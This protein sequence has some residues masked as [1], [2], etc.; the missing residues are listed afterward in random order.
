[1]RTGIVEQKGAGER[2][3]GKPLLGSE[4]QSC[5]PHVEVRGCC[6]K[7]IGSPQFE[8]SKLRAISY[9]VAEDDSFK[10]SPKVRTVWKQDG[11]EVFQWPCGGNYQA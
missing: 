8:K 9:P 10:N 7:K 2:K 3:R 1:M 4:N 11:N 5:K 6:P